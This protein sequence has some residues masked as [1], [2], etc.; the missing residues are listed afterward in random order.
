MKQHFDGKNDT[1]FVIK[2]FK[3]GANGITYL[4]KGKKSGLKVIVKRPKLDKVEDQDLGRRIKRLNGFLE[5]EG[6]VLSKLKGV[7]GVAQLLDQG[8]AFHK[9]KLGRRINVNVYQYIPGVN[10]EEWTTQYAKYHHFRK[11]QGIHDSRLWFTL[12]SQLIQILTDVHTKKIV[13]GDLW[14]QN[15]I[16]K[17]AN[18]EMFDPAYHPK[19]VLIDFGWGIAFD[20]LISRHADRSIWF[21]HSAPERV[22]HDGSNPRWYSPVDVYSLGNL[23]LFLA[24]GDCTVIPFKKGLYKELG[25]GSGG[26]EVSGLEE[27]ADPYKPR[28]EIKAGIDSVIASNN[29]ELYKTFPAITELIMFCMRPSVSLRAKHAGAVGQQMRAL[30]P[31]V[32]RTPPNNIAKLRVCG[33]RFNSRLQQACKKGFHPMLSR[34]LLNDLD[35]IIRGLGGSQIL[36]LERQGERDDLILDITSCLSEAQTGDTIQGVLALAL[37]QEQNLGPSGRVMASLTTAA[38]YGAAIELVLLVRESDKSSELFHILVGE[39]QKRIQE[40][41]NA[42]NKRGGK[43]EVKVLTLNRE[44][45]KKFS[46]EHGSFIMIKHKDDVLVMDADFEQSGGRC[47][48]LRFGSRTARSE[49]IREFLDPA[50]RD[51][52]KAGEPIET[53]GQEKGASKQ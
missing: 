18:P 11:F 2:K 43:L 29:P 48:A 39:F 53:L 36:L 45:Y 31:I 10:L 46:K 21:P 40:C 8:Q 14:H 49:D 44:N 12:A 15:I 52:F 27:S 16:V 33:A 1:Y 19:L 50:F 24:A 41:Q 20:E 26:Y 47:T 5:V 4:A 38:Q 25:D 34:L 7:R 23:L 51:Y 13:H 28:A 30:T 22:E 32:A 42:C 35:K 9:G 6:D 37:M 17:G 3:A